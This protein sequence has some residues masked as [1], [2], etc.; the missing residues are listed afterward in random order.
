[1]K[2]NERNGNLQKPLKVIIFSLFLGFFSLVFSS[3]SFAAEPSQEW[4]DRFAAA[5]QAMTDGDWESAVKIQE[6]LIG[7]GFISLSLL[8]NLAIARAKQHALAQSL[9]AWLAARSLDPKDLIVQE[10]I[11]NT[12]AA[13]QLGPDAVD[14][15][16]HGP[17]TAWMS[18][19][20]HHD[21]MNLMYAAMALL[22][23]CVFLIALLVFRGDGKSHT[24]LM[25]LIAGFW[26]AVTAMVWVAVISIYLQIGTWGAVTNMQG[27]ALRIAANE[28]A[29]ELTRL[30]LGTPVFVT[31]NTYNRWL[32][33][34]TSDGQHGFLDAL[35]VRVIRLSF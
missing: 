8:K 28:T 25:K 16:A 7:E 26:I 10:G 35:E 11:T 29:T 23:G 1:M 15:S 18:R 33:V 3:L 4:Q 12:L 6:S 19:Q 17:F 5:N 20:T 14:L 32:E 27:A 13:L 2:G 30:K 31:N 21:V 34:R 24:N 9:A 22:F